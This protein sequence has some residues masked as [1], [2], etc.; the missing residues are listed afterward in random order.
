MCGT[1]LWHATDPFFAQ[2]F[3]E[4]NQQNSGTSGTSP[5]IDIG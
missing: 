2:H 3:M 1:H 5:N 4:S